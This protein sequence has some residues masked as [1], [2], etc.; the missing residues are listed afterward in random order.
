MQELQSMMVKRQHNSITSGI[1]LISIEGT[2]N[3]ARKM[4]N[5][6]P[7]NVLR[8]DVGNEIAAHHHNSESTPSLLAPLRRQGKGKLGRS[9]NVS[10]LEATI[11]A[12]QALGLRNE[13][14]RR[15]LEIAQTKVN[16]LVEYSGKP[17]RY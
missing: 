2:W 11:I 7:S 6:L 13:D 3:N 5:K 17:P 15:I 8:L 12:L 1:L 16:R 4:A 10:T 9:D 14:A